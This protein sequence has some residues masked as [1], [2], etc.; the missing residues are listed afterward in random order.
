MRFRQ[1]LILLIVLTAATLETRGQINGCSTLGQTPS[2]A[3]PV[4]GISTFKQESVPA[5]KGA[6][7]PVPCTDNAQYSDINPFWYKFTCYISG[8]LGFLI[9]P[10]TSTD[11]YD[12]QIFDVT[13]RDPNDVYTDHSLFVSGNWSSNPDTTGTRSNNNGSINCAGPAYPNTNSMPSLIQGHDYLLLVSHFTND[14]QS[15]YSLVFS[16]GTGSI[17]DPL[18]PAQKSATPVCF[19]GTIK[20]ALNKKMKCSSLAADGSDFTITPLPAGVSITGATANSCSS[21]FD[22]DSVQLTLN[23]SLIV[24][25]TYT[26][27]AAMGSDGNTL[28]DYCNNQIPVGQSVTFTLVAPLPTPMD[29]MVPIGCA[30]NQLQLVFKKGILCSSVAADG[31]DFSVTGPVPVTVSGVSMS[32]DP[33]GYSNIIKVNLSAPIQ[34]AGTFRITLKMG[35]DGNTFYDACGL[36][37]PT[38][39]LSFITSDTVSAEA[40]KTSIIGGCRIDTVDITY[41]SEDGV[42]QW[43]WVFDNTD[44]S[45]AQNPPRHI[46]PASGTHPLLVIVSNGVCSDTLKTSIVLNNEVKAAFEAPNIICPRDYAQYKNNSTGAIDYWDWDLGDGTT[47]NLQ[48]PADHLYP[49]TGVETNYAVRLI[50]VNSTIGCQDTAYQKIDVLKSCYIAVPTA[51]TPNGDGLNDY[52]YPLNAFKADNLVF[53]VFNRQGQMVFQSH[54]WTDRWDGRV[55]GNDAPAGTYVW[56]LQYIDRDSKKPFLRKGT[57]I[58]IR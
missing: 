7:I 4:C 26:V 17:T 28:Q 36:P 23:G 56:F 46:Y 2:T 5:C 33:S 37:T 9:T 31:S 16:G 42:N 52:L 47:S 10:N 14:N 50:V 40:F 51:F 43:L 12:W 24:G 48:T 45:R 19:G 1:L 44:T 29:S 25:N 49:I 38:S 21:G 57:S 6:R 18:I 27:A 54:S 11:D 53:Q 3:F 15:G 41:P 35:S 8:T 13:G 30:P 55:N 58:L 20:V 39:S 32:C 34:T 22:L